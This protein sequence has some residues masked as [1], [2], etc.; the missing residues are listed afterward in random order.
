MYSVGVCLIPWWQ[1][2]PAG[3]HR[4]QVPPG[5]APRADTILVMSAHCWHS[6][7]SWAMADWLAMAHL[8][9]WDWCHARMIRMGH[10]NLGLYQ[11]G[12]YPLV[13]VNKKLWKDPPFYSWENPRF[14]LG[15]EAMASIANCCQLLPEGSRNHPAWGSRKPRNPA[16]PKGW[17]KPYNQMILDK[18]SINWCRISQPSTV[19]LYFLSRYLDLSIFLS[20]L[21]VSIYIS[22]YLSVC[23]S[24]YLSV[25]LSK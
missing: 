25:Y 24:V 19:S 3:L 9:G 21:L 5:S 22:I 16:P 10:V 18:P 2:N 7:A 12:K 8:I 13:N 15:H 6:E 14:R 11:S 4:Q 17:L 1:I 20:I 23:L